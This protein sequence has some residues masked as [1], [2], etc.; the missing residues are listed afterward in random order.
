[1][2]NLYLEYEYWFAVTQ[3]MLAML[4]MG[5]TLTTH[6]FKEVLTEP[7]AV[8]IGLAIQLLAVPLI[9]FATITLLGLIEGIA[10]GIALIAS[11]P[12]GTVSNIFTHFAKG[13]TALSITLTAVTTVACLATTPF[14]LGLLIERYMPANF[15]MPAGQIAI[16]I[17]LCLL[18]PLL[19]GMLYLKLLPGSAVSFSKACIRGSLLVI[20]MIVIGSLGAG[21]LDWKAFGAINVGIICGFMAAMALINFFIARLLG[22]SKADSAAIEMEVIVRNINL[23]LLI[24]ASLF[25]A[26]IGQK[27]PLGDIVLFSLLMFGAAQLIV[28]TGLIFNARHKAKK[29]V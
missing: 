4:G 29:P 17:G 8:S 9:A 21:R 25:P 7:K 22:L 12:G 24:K 26:V 18:L 20:V 1:M 10:V 2:F 13:N 28:G 6:D 5:A 27:D 19:V 16:E 3:L 14:I 11:I 23:G 15:E